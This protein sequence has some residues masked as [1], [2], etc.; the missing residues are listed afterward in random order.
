MMRLK[1]VA[2]TSGT[3]EFVGAS[4]GNTTRSCNTH[5]CLAAGGTAVGQPAGG[6]SMPWCEGQVEPSIAAVDYTSIARRLLSMQA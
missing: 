2:D 4:G 1:C 5:T 3:T 6:G